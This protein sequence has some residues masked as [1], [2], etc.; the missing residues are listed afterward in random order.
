[1]INTLR[2]RCWC[3]S[4]QPPELIGSMHDPKKHGLYVICPNCGC[5]SAVATS[6]SRAWDAWDK[7]ELEKDD[8]N[9]TIYEMIRGE[10]SDETD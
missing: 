4:E 6:P 8:E 3:G 9:Y 2:R 7:M 1:M 10:D 5:R